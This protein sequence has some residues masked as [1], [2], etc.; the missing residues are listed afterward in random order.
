[1]YIKVEDKNDWKYTGEKTVADVRND[2]AA[3][4]QSNIYVNDSDTWERLVR[5]INGYEGLKGK[6]NVLLYLSDSRDDSSA[7]QVHFVDYRRQ[8]YI[9]VA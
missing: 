4:R 1:M 9:V 3:S 8:H 7:L 5:I 2:L 6:G